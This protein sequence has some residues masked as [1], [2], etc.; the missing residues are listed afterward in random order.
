MSKITNPLYLSSTTVVIDTSVLSVKVQMGGS[1]SSLLDSNGVTL[2]ALYSY[3]KQVWRSTPQYLKFPFPMIAITSE[4]FEFINGWNLADDVSKHL[5][6]DGGWVLRSISGVVQEKWANITTLGSFN[7]PLSDR[8]YY[9]QDNSVAVT[10]AVYT[11]PVNQ[12]VQIYGDSTHGN[13][14]YQSFFKIFLRVQGKSYDFYDLVASQN[15]VTLD[16]RK[17]AMP[18]SNSIDLKINDSDVVIAS[19]SPW[20]GIT[21]TYM[22]VNIKG[23]WG[24]GIA[25]SINDVV[26]SGGTW[27]KC[28]TTHTSNIFVSDQI[29][30][31]AYNG[32]RLIGSNYY[33]FKTIINANQATAEQV[34]EKVQY[35]LRQSGTIDTAASIIGNTADSIVYFVGQTLTSS[36]GVFIDNFQASDTN[37]L[38]FSDYAGVA[39]TFPFVASLELIFNDNLIN[40]Y[41]TSG[42]PAIYKVYYTTNPSGNYGTASSV[43]VN[44][45]S[46]NPM[47]GNVSGSVANNGYAFYSFDYDFNTQGGRIAGTDADITVIAIGQQVAQFIMQQGRITRSTGNVIQ[48]VSSPER[49]Y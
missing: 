24:T 43:I 30:W 20:S 40:E 5:I 15:L 11:G 13:F 49:N 14:N 31:I 46:G 1:G 45:A 29:K 26:Q 38:V 41:T 12:A 22:N 3:L 39:R 28:V 37:R 17:Y 33:A 21:L 47:I 36:Q 9:Q 4:Q 10:G 27:W 23:P 18:L 48:L 25:Y 44:D 32:Q 6:R 16:Y 8:A 19:T 2:Q 34:Y 7:N 42:I 35:L